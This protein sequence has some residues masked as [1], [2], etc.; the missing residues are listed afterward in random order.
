MSEI[1]KSEFQLAQD[2]YPPNGWIKS[3]FRYF[4]TDT[5]PKDMYV[6][7]I[8]QGWEIFLFVVGFIGTVLEHY[9]CSLALLHLTL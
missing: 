4:S 8:I 9:R 2:K 1:S 7:R 6:R 5:K 3:A